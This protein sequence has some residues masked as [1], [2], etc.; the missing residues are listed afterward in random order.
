MEI[1]RLC[2]DR[3]L[4]GNELAKA[5]LLN[6]FLPKVSSLYL[7]KTSENRLVFWRFQGGY[8]WTIRLKLV[9]YLLQSL[10]WHSS[11]VHNFLHLW[12]FR[13]ISF[14]WFMWGLQNIDTCPANQQVAI[15]ILKQAAHNTL[16]NWWNAIFLKQP[17]MSVALTSKEE[18]KKKPTY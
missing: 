11:A 8:K 12:I 14:H 1:L 4:V 9:E 13:T 2:W 18:S 6:P 10:N 5:I 15:I 17:D 3:Y 16:S 7:L